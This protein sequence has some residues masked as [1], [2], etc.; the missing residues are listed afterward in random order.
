MAGVKRKYIKYPDPS[1]FEEVMGNI[2]KLKDDLAEA[3]EK[4][5]ISKKLYD[6]DLQKKNYLIDRL[7]KAY[8]TDL[9][10]FRDY[11]NPDQVKDYENRRNND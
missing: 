11:R 5:A 3:R 4:A 8:H 6:K 1:T 2:F 9:E 10:K 7:S